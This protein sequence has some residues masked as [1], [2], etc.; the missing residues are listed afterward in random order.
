MNECVHIWTDYYCGSCLE[1]IGICCEECG[2]VDENN[3]EAPPYCE[4]CGGWEGFWRTMNEN[5]KNEDVYEE[6]GSREDVKDE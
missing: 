5:G 6:L 1:R 2:F 4:E 3:P